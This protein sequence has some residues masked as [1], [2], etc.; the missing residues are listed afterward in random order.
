MINA[1]NQRC[2]AS[3][4]CSSEELKFTRQ[5]HRRGSKER[6]GETVTQRNTTIRTASLCILCHRS[7]RDLS[8]SSAKVKSPRGRTV[9]KGKLIRP[10]RNEAVLHGRP[11]ETINESGARWV[12]AVSRIHAY[13]ASVIL[14][15]PDRPVQGLFTKRQPVLRRVIRLLTDPFRSLTLVSFRQEEEFRITRRF[16]RI[17][18]SRREDDLLMNIAG[19]SRARRVRRESDRI[20]LS[21]WIVVFNS[22]D[23]C[24]FTQWE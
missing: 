7:P 4:V 18:K 10:V 5:M 14:C 16:T 9:P 3:C 19:M 12:L 8:R 15:A 1:G 22:A 23:S 20:I 21:G 11:A 24:D 2:R 17:V 13:P 6:V